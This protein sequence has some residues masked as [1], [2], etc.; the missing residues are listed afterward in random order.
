M[1]GTG[2]GIPEE[3]EEVVKRLD[4]LQEKVEEKK[5]LLVVRQHQRSARRRR[6]S[7]VW[8]LASRRQ[9]YT[10]QEAPAR[11]TPARST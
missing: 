5:P 10:V 4:L 2:S 7:S 6:L 1:V 9:L 3:G 11:S 8:R